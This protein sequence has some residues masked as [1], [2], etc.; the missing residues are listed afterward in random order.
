MCK[1]EDID[2]AFIPLRRCRHDA[3]STRGITRAEHL[4]V[5]TSTHAI[6]PPAP[7]R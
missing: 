6:I 2:D 7:E 1:E 5:R 3:F 4:V